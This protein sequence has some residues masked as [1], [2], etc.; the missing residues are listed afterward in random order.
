MLYLLT[1]PDRMSGELI[2]ARI[3][4]QCV[5]VYAAAVKEAYSVVTSAPHFKGLRDVIYVEV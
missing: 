1:F 4:I 5:I 3:V 2:R